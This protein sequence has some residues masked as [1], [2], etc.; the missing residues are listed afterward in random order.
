ME[1][2]HLTGWAP[3]GDAGVGAVLWGADGGGAAAAWLA[4]AAVDPQVLLD[5]GIAC[6]GA[7]VAGGF[8][9]V[10]QEEFAR[11]GDE[12]GEL[13][14]GERGDLAEG[15][16]AASEGDLGFEDV[17]ESGERGLIEESGAEFEIALGSELRDGES[18][19]EV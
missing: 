11:G 17:A 8:G 10:G 19:I 6:G 15:A 14:F 1:I 12:I 3:E 16:E 7:P 18:G 5:S 13:L 4:G 2:L 9:H